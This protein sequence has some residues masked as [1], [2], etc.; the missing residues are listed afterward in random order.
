M[1]NPCNVPVIILVRPQLEENIGFTARVMMNF[2]FSRLRLIDPRCY[3]LS[4]K[5]VSVACNASEILSN[6]DVFSCI[7]DSLSDL[8]LVFA[9]SARRR[10]LDVSKV[11]LSQ[12]IIFNKNTGFMFGPENSGLSNY[13]LS[14]VDKL[15]T[16]ETSENYKSLNL[17][18]SVAIL[19]YELSKRNRK[20]VK[21]IGKDRYANKAELDFFFRN[22]E[23]ELTDSN[24]FKTKEKILKSMVNIKNMFK[25]HIVTSN[26]V[27]ILHGI[28]KALSNKD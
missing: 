12:D 27:K 23:K 16:I 28:V 20:E 22:L 6:A 1:L 13:D 5:C 21:K 2:G 11:V 18:H 17:S 3:H 10:D 8:N 7:S 24:F 25:K 4:N 26:E 14:L 19:C 9:L 15:I